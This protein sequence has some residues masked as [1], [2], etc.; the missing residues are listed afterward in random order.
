[1]MH[2]DR[3]EG[4]KIY[5]ANVPCTCLTGS[6]LFILQ[7]CVLL[8]CLLPHKIKHKGVLLAKCR[9][10]YIIFHSVPLGALLCVEA[11]SY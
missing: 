9:S 11:P 7:F 4:M 2:N 10:S 3:I 8:G 6:R 5:F 1:M